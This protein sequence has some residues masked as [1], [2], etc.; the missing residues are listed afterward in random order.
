[1]LSPSPNNRNPILHTSAT[2]FPLPPAAAISSDHLA[3][4][5]AHRW[6]LFSAIT[7]TDGKPG[8]ELQQL[9]IGEAF[10]IVVVTTRDLPSATI[11]VEVGNHRVISVAAVPAM[12]EDENQG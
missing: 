10:D 5:N 6:L 8:M 1:M 2:F 4:S 7:K 9:E 11:V 3:P 12:A